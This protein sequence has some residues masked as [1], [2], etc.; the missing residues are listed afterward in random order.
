MWEEEREGVIFSRKK[1]KLSWGK[2]QGVRRNRAKDDGFLYI[3]I[4]EIREVP[5]CLR[6]SQEWNCGR[7]FLFLVSFIDVWGGRFVLL[8]REG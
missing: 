4:R 6:L 3:S 5:H 2:K 1:S 7:F 8:L